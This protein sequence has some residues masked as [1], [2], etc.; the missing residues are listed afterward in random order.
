[1]LVK[2][3]IE[4][5]F[6]VMIKKLFA[7]INQKVEKDPFQW[8]NITKEYRAKYYSNI[9]KRPYKRA[10]EYIYKEKHLFIHLLLISIIYTVINIIPPFFG[11]LAITVTSGHSVGFL[12]DMINKA[13]DIDNIKKIIENSITGSTANIIMQFGL[14]IIIGIIYVLGRTSLDYLK[15]FLATFFSQNINRD[16]QNEMLK[17]MLHTDLAYFGQESE[18][19][20]ISRINE[21]STLAIFLS[22]TLISLIT[23]PLTIILTLSVLFMMNYK[24]TLICIL[25]APLIAFSI[26][27][28]NKI[29]G[30]KIVEQK[31][32][33]ENISTTIQENI[34]AIEVIK[35]FSTED[36]EV[37][38]H[39]E[40]TNILIKFTRKLIM[41]ISLSRPFSELVMIFAMLI[42]LAYG[43]YLVFNEEMPFDFL[44]G[45]LL[46]MLNIS[47]PVRN[48]SSVLVEFKTSK[49]LLQRVWAIIDLPKENDNNTNNTE[50]QKLSTIKKSICFNDVYFSYP[51]RNTEKSFELSSININ[52]NKGD[53]VAFV[54]NSGSGKSTLVNL[55]P[56]LILPSR[57]SITFDDVDIS[58]LNTK[59]IR[60]CIGFVGQESILFYGTIRE[61]I[62]Y[63]KINATDEEIEEAIQIAHAKEFIDKL[64]LGVDTNIGSSGIML[65]GGQKQR[66]ALARAVL[67]K[68]SILILDEVTSS[69]DMES[70][71]HIQNALN[72]IMHKQTTFVIAHRFSTIKHAN[73]IYVL[74]NGQI[75]ES[76]THNE[77]IKSN[78]KYNKLY[79]LQFR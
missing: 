19:T 52:V 2:N 32:L 39:I 16:V 55:I 68:P 57:G 77:L 44:W 46:Y 15:S 6:I 14:I 78:G 53:I 38:R 70:E 42:I 21:S 29:I 13:P 49:N 48:L 3:D 45:F 1:M 34:H 63:G 4:V 17:S 47:Q 9:E 61:N 66:I 5:I 56:K 11:Q 31:K 7:K 36:I 71:L 75:I 51:T 50:K 79:S 69:L 27:L 65:S 72:D 59:S 64:P 35:M 40:Y 8:A 74:E 41:I 24:L 37:E 30:N 23:T 73:M 10:F 33:S 18:A 20:L 26:T 25:A 54:G 62:T 76:G 12:N 58:N 22:K 43:G 28:L 67:R 60:Q